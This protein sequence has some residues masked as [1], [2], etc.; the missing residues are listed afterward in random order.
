MKH[1]I[2]MFLLL[3]L[4]S[5]GQDLPLY[6]GETDYCSFGQSK[7][8]TVVIMVMGQSNAANAGEGLFQS[9]CSNT[10]NFYQGN[11]FPLHDPLLG[12]NGQGGS[13]WS[14]LA[15]RLIEQG[16]AKE[17]IIAPVAIG[18][19]SIE[20][21]IPG[22][23]LHYLITETV[24]SLTA[25]NLKV[26]YVLWHQGESNNTVLNP[27]VSSSQNALN[28]KNN[29]MLLVQSLRNKGISSPIFPAITSRCGA[30]PID[31]ELQAAQLS[32]AN[33]TLGIYNGPNTDILG[34]E[35]RYDE[36]H[37]NEEGLNVHALLWL[38]ILLQH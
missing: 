15:F 14:R 27:S 17:I 33:D 26:D 13:V 11:L 22:G 29:F 16:F 21:W 36:C 5:C 8:D 20:Q 4:A 28:Y 1:L 2:P 37:F 23:N 6:S 38:D 10:Q 3:F 35:Y 7:Y 24:N 9:P 32:L 12:A 18:G 31:T 30:L 34:L 19:T 25:A